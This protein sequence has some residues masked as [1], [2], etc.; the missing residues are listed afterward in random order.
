MSSNTAAA[1]VSVTGG[2]LTVTPKT[3]A[4][5]STITMSDGFGHSFTFTVSLTTASLVIN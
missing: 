5:F 3:T 4:G 1:A 2:V